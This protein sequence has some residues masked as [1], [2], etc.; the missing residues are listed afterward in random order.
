MAEWNL[1]EDE[2]GAPYPE[3][4]QQHFRAMCAEAWREGWQAAEVVVDLD[5]LPCFAHTVFP[6]GYEGNPYEDVR[7]GGG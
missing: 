3:V 6:E 2:D 1:V 7:Y 5:G 4:M